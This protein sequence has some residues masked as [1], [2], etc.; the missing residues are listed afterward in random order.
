MHFT[1]KIALGFLFC[2]FGF[3][4]IHAQ[5]TLPNLTIESL[6]GKKVN[7]KE[8]ATNGKITV[9]SFWATWCKP[10]KKELNNIAEIYEEWQDNYDVQ[11]IAVS[12]DDARTSSKVKTYVDGQSW[13]Y[14]VLLDKNQDLKKSLNFQTVP[15]TLLVDRKGNIV[16][17]HQGYVE[18]DE[19]TLEDKIKELAK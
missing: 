19:Y 17:R 6:E 16:D 3:F 11:V 10:C 18:G 15:F 4:S 7:I 14:T 5:G 8:L 12:I 1:K 13:D 9:F 2:S